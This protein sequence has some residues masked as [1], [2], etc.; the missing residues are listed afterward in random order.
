MIEKIILAIVV[1]AAVLIYILP[2]AAGLYIEQRDRKKRGE[3]DTSKAQYDERQ[4]LIRLKASQHALYVL[5]GYLLVWLAAEAGGVLHWENR[6]AA[7]LAGGLM[8]ALVVWNGEC[9]LRNIISYCRTCGY[10]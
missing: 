9:I 8:L 10:I 2:L 6:T 5:G 3:P 1:V 7:L 4:K